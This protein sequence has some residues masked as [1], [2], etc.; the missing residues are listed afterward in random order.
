VLASGKAYREILRIAER[1]TELIVIGVHS[2]GVADML[3]LGSTTQLVV[4][5]APCPVLTIR[6]S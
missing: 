3:F 6:S 1:S 5:Q 4:R 2:R